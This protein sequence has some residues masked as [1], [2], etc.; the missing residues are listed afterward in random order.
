MT[1]TLP[2]PIEFEL[3]PGWIA[4]PPDEVGAPDAAFVALHAEEPP[5]GFTANITIG[6]ALRVDRASLAEIADESVQSLAA[7]AVA[8]TLARRNE[9]GEPGAPGLTQLVRIRERVGGT[10]RSL[11][12]C[13]VYLSMSDVDDARKRV[14]VQLVLTATDE[15]L[16]GVIRDFQWFVARVRPE[17]AESR[18]SR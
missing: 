7:R 13:Q 9:F 3:P 11:A 8:V 6:G 10:E 15:Q 16:D 2:V 4:A 1:T 17:P 14:V 12:Q 18:R 5:A